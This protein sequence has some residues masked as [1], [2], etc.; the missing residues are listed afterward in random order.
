MCIRDSYYTV[1]TITANYPRAAFVQ[2]FDQTDKFTFDNTA[3]IAYTPIGGSKDTPKDTGSGSHGIPTPGGDLT[4]VEQLKFDSNNQTVD[5]NSFYAS[6]FPA[7]DGGVQFK[8]SKW[9][10]RCV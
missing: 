5:Y 1:Y 4:I 2:D 7:P 9:D 8:L 6:A 3:E 10:E